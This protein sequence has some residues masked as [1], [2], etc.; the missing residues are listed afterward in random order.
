MC[1]TSSLP[2]HPSWYMHQ[3]LPNREQEMEKAVTQHGPALW[4]PLAN[5]ASLTWGCR[6]ERGVPG[7]WLCLECS[8]ESGGSWLGEVLLSQSHLLTEVLAQVT[9]LPCPLRLPFPF[10]RV[11]DVQI[12]FCSKHFSTGASDGVYILKS[13]PWMLLTWCT[14]LKMLFLGRE[15]D[16]LLQDLSKWKDMMKLT[17][18]FHMQT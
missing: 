8:R 5:R 7:V 9:R 6:G 10:P 16:T 17:G 11:K 2:L 1:T 4:E 13:V 3:S 15:K 18:W 12:G 14:V